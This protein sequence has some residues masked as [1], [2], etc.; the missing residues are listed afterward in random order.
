MASQ[1][2]RTSCATKF[3]LNSGT[4]TGYARLPHSLVMQSGFDIPAIGLSTWQGM[5]HLAVRPPEATHSR[6]IAESLLL[7][8]SHIEMWSFASSG[9]DLIRCVCSTEWSQIDRKS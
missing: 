9:S 8:V 1:R 3:R 2:G 5:V 4:P 6:G 7:I